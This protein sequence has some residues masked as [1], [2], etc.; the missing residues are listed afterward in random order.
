VLYFDLLYFIPLHLFLFQ[1][2]FI[3]GL[4][5]FTHYFFQPL[6]RLIQTIPSRQSPTTFFI[7]ECISTFEKG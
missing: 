6:K 4:F 2:F 3:H 1:F 7:N 5:L